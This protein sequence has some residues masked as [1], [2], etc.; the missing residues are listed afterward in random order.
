[1]SEQR[2]DREAVR[3]AIIEEAEYWDKTDTADM[4][5][6]ETEWFT[7]E[8]TER[9]D[10][11]ERCA[12]AMDVQI[13]NLLLAGGRVILHN[14]PQYVCRTPGCGNT[15]LP[16]AIKEIADQIEAL[17]QETFP[18]QPISPPESPVQ[19][20]WEMLVAQQTPSLEPTLVRESHPS[21]GEKESE[22]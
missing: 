1:M 10:R 11:C 13:T 17:V 19:P 6:Q 15:Q 16:S 9:E 5:A 20:M 21:Y 8:W 2:V 14:V 12:G 3:Q 22:E 18:I 4:M 7:F